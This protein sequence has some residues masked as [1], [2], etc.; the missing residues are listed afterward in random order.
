MNPQDNFSERMVKN[1]NKP[2]LLMLLLCNKTQIRSIFAFQTILSTKKILTKLNKA[3]MSRKDFARRI[4]KS[5][6]GFLDAI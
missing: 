1:G 3:W 5:F 2:G 4:K 6:Q